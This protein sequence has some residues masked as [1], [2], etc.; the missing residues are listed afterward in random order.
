VDLK[1][2]NPVKRVD[3][4]IFFIA[5]KCECKGIVICAKVCLEGIVAR[6]V[7]NKEGI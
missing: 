2:L 7:A 6:V 4:Y 5:N 1:A 3:L